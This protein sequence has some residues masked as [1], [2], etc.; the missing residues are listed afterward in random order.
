M[1]LLNIFLEFWPNVRRGGGGGDVGLEKVSLA[2][3]RLMIRSRLATCQ[4]AAVSTVLGCS[5]DF[6]KH[7]AVS[8]QKVRKW[9]KV[10]SDCTNC[11]RILGDMHSAQ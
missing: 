9:K 10:T 3:V 1:K 5:K 4:R 6:A 7:C 2:F 8:S 11:N